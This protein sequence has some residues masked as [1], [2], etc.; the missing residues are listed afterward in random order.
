MTRALAA[1][2]QPSE[3]KWTVVRGNMAGSVRLMSA[4]NFA[5]GRNPECEFVIN[6]DPKCSRRHATVTWTTAG[7]EIQ[8]LSETNPVFINGR[9]IDRQILQNGDIVLIGS[10]EIQFNTTTQPT[11]ANVQLRRLAVA[12]PQEAYP[13]GPAPMRP[14]SG[15]GRSA[16]Q[17]SFPLTFVY[18]GIGLLVLYMLFHGSPT[19][20]KALQLRGEQQVQE[21]I[22]SAEKL[23]QAASQG[24]RRADDS[25]MGRQAQENY[26]RGFRDFRKGQYERALDS[27]N[28][29][30]A[31][32]PSHTLCNRYKSLSQ[33]KFN[34]LV[35]LQIVLGRR[36]RDQN[37]FKEC[38][39]AFRNVMVMVKDANS[40]AYREAKANYDAC[41]AL[42]EGRY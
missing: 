12:P 20:K 41:F 5:I 29:C 37:Q 1:P 17:E 9:Q 35:Q 7:P 6:N 2:P 40:A 25:M 33:R 39:A 16:K 3:T 42:S 30:L 22:E 38:L 10:T 11:S 13:S 26:V 24:G 21:A 31:L 4:A 32:N 14:R 8:S 36:H 34:E 23:Q 27:F 28:T 15:R 19:K 18:I